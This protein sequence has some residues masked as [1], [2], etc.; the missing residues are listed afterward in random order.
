MGS[1][2]SRAA[3][4]TE[5]L[6]WR[7]GFG[8]SPAERAHFAAVGLDGAIASLLHPRGRQLRGRAPRIHGQP[9]DPIN[10]YGQD[11]LWWLD[12][13]VRTNQPLVERM[14]LNLHDHFATSNDKVGDPSLM[15]AQYRLMRRYALGNFGKLAHGMVKDHAMQWWLDLIESN[16]EEPNENFARE[17]MEL[18][19][20]GIGHYTERDIR[21]AARA[22]TG[23]AFH[24]DTKRYYFNAEAHDTGRKRI[25]GHVGR[26]T[27]D[28]VIDLCLNHPAHAPF[29]CKKLWGYFIPGVP[30]AR[31]LRT[32]V[33]AYKRS[34]RELRPVLDIILRHP[35]LYAR[36]NDPDLVKPPVVYVAGMLRALRVPVDD[37]SWTYILDEM[38]Q[39]PFYPPNVGGWP[40]NDAWLSTNT[41][42][43]RWDAVNTIIGRH[44]YDLNDDR[45]PK[46][47]EAPAKSL[48]WAR[49][50]TGH[51]FESPATRTRMN[52]V[53]GTIRPGASWEVQH[54]VAERR[55]VIRLFLLLGP[56]ALV[57]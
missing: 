11:S 14:T 26:F 3:R 48:A 2:T 34:R 37:D 12:R 24:Y 42:R 16:K 15:M 28:G 56:D 27:P 57:H 8:A 43:A 40:S 23:F 25:F 6:F 31:T 46:K 10:R 49:K 41:L 38:G 19:T 9:L 44:G 21:E 35:R 33:R 36:L 51:P 29:I 5:R 54:A 47:G 52:H 13:L 7:A 55:R 1:L 39:R 53:A 20:L 30:S 18:F 50:V 4:V 22:L 17:L 45:M 32:M